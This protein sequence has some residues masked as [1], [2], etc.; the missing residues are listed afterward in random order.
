MKKKG[1]NKVG[2]PKKA[3]HQSWQWLVKNTRTR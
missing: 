3:D 1:V 2:L